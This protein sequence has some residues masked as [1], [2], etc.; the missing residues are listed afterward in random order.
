MAHRNYNIEQHDGGDEDEADE[1]DSNVR[2]CN[3]SP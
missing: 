3:T 2:L 1:E